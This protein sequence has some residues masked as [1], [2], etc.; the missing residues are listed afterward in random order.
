M[1]V[2]N[3]LMLGTSRENWSPAH[4]HGSKTVPAAESALIQEVPKDLQNLE[5]LAH[6]YAPKDVEVET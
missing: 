2:E 6:D 4:S 3:T 5:Q 1:R